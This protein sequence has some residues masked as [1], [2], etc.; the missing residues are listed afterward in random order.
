MAFFTR[1]NL[2]VPVLS[3]EDSGFHVDDLDE[4]RSESSTL[5]RG[6]SLGADEE[7]EEEDVDDEDQVEEYSAQEGCQCGD[8]DETSTS[9]STSTSERQVEGQESKNPTEG[10]RFE[11][12]VDRVFGVEV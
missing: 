10:E 1:V 6:T 7:E 8:N 3:P 4:S 9:T 11:Y 12:V 5:K 2:T